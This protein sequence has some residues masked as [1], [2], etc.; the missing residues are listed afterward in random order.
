[1]TLLLT[2]FNALGLDQISQTEFDL[3]D[4]IFQYAVRQ[5]NLNMEQ[6]CIYKDKMKSSCEIRD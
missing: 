6:F 3:N 1:M 2:T 4:V 5:Q